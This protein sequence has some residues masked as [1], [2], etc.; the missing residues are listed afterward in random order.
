MCGGAVEWR[1]S[2]AESSPWWTLVSSAERYHD[3]PIDS[4]HCIRIKGVES[5]RCMYI[6]GKQWV[7]QAN[8]GLE[9]LEAEENA[10][11]HH[12]RGNA[13]ALIRSRHRDKDEP[14]ISKVGSRP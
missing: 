2:Q 4:G 10:N 13:G 6:T 7:V 9:G 5:R 8:Q 1:Y 14:Q 3:R 11:P 12:T